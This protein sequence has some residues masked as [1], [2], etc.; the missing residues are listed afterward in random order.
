[1]FEA[2]FILTTV[3]TGTRVARF[4]LQELGSHVYKPL[5]RQRWMPGIIATSFLVV[6]AWAYLIHSGSISTIWP[7]FGVS[8]QLLAAIAFGVGTTV[9]I[10]SGKARYAW[11]TF[12]PMLFM[13]TTTLAASWELINMFLGKAAAAAVKTDALTFKIDAFLVFLMAALAVV[14]LLDMLF[15]W[16]RYFSE[17]VKLP[18]RES[19]E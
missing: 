2:L 6:A 16:Y 17:T 5:A 12:V 11:T 9:I 3:D 10:K 1:M 13:F 19:A 14:A 18:S 4:L 7:M 8:N 15:T